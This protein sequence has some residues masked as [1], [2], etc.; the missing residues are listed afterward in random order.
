MKGVAH[1]HS[2]DYAHLDLK[3]DNILLDENLNAKIFSYKR[4]IIY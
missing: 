2:K 1:I 3:H 4:N